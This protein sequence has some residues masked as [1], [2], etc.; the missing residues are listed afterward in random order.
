MRELDRL[1]N[2]PDV[3]DVQTGSVAVA[4]RAYA[5]GSPAPSLITQLFAHRMRPNV[6]ILGPVAWSEAIVEAIAVAQERPPICWVPD[7]PLP[8]RA[9]GRAIVIRDIATLS[10]GRQAAWI[11]WLDAQ[12]DR[13]Y[14]PQIVVTSSIA[15]FPLVTQGMFLKDLYYRL[16]TVLL[17]ASR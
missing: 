14:R 10:L 5:H 7:M 15:V 6:L 1:M 16:N 9:D 17:E 3:D 13:T 4:P 8:A 2:C 12:N 11:S